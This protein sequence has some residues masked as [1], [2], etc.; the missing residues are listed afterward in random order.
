MKNILIPT[1]FSEN[2]WNAIQYGLALFKKR[3]CNFH[4]THIHPVAA[5]TGGEAA[6]Y[7][8]YEILEEGILRESKAALEQLLKK[9]EHLPFNT[10]HTFQTS[11]HYGFFTDH[12]KQQVQELDIDLI[13]MG[14]K[15]ASGLKAVS[16]GSNTGNVMTKGKCPVLA[17]PENVVYAKPKEIGFPTDFQSGY[18]IEVLKNLNELVLLHRSALRFVYVST[19]GSEFNEEQIKNR[20]YLKNYFED[21]VHSFHTLT[22]NKLE[23]A[24]QCFVESRD[25]DMLVMVAKNLNFLER[26]L[27]RPTVEKIS[28]HTSV[29]FLVLHE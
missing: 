11:V 23:E 12:I 16:I 20:E 5:H 29:P 8:S 3:S 18:D 2:A 1:D 25:L 7:V 28:Y 21:S 9:I 26:I 15:G 22:A 17:V 19:K 4:F 14:T 6:M 27:F 24:I 13:I 10:K